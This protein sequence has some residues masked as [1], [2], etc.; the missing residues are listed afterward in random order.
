MKKIY[1]QRFTIISLEMNS[2]I[3][4]FF[5]LIIESI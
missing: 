1:D 2:K 5:N 3:I 4:L